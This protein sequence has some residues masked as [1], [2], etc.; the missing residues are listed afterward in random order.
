MS[1]AKRD[2]EQ[3]AGGSEQQQHK[4]QTTN[5]AEGPDIKRVRL[6]DGPSLSLA[7]DSGDATPS[8]PTTSF[9]KSK[10][11]RSNNRGGQQQRGGRGGGGGG[12]GGRGS[13]NNNSNS[14]YSRGSK[15]KQREWGPKKDSNDPA[16]LDSEAVK[17]EDTAGEGKSKIPKKKVALLIG[18]SGLGYSG[19]QV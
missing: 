12:R 6:D 16:N 3:A 2:A 14:N 19:S 13:N 15:G 9:A 1:G 8:S 7:S 17:N 18:Y 5:K 4:E 11:E 10:N